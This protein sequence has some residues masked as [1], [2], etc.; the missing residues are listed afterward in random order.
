MC[1]LL[2]SVSEHHS[3][4]P[5]PCWLV[6]IGFGIDCRIGFKC[7]FVGTMKTESCVCVCVCVCQCRRKHTKN[8]IDDLESHESYRKGVQNKLSKWRPE[9]ATN[10]QR[11]TVLHFW[12]QRET[13]KRRKREI[14]RESEIAWRVCVHGH[15]HLGH[16]YTFT[17]TPTHTSR[18][19]RENCYG[20]TFFFLFFCHTF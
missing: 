16:I 3:T 14:L 12:G 13:L 4:F 18:L 9:N 1:F 17:N 20:Y 5:W 11:A 2:L 8:A 7:N 15:T 10:R 6:D 19:W